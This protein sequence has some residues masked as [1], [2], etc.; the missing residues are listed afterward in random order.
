[1][2]FEN[3]ARDNVTLACCRLKSQTVDNWL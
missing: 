2:W 3:C 1:L